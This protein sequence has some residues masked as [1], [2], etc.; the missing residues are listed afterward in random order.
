MDLSI[1]TTHLSEVIKWVGTV[2]TAMV[3]ESG[4]LA[5]L[6]PLLMVGV[7]ISALLL[8]VKVI[9]SFVWGA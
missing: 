9:R 8:A 1:V 7:S 5:E 3:S 4:E 6:T 2:I